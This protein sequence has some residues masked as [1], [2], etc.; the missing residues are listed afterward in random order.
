M[1]KKLIEAVMIQY[2]CKRT[3]AKRMIRK[4]SEKEKE[5]VIEVNEN[6]KKE[7]NK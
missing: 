5:R 2:M 7:N 3:I 4:M 1:E 6:Y